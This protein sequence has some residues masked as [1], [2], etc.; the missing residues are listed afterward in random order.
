MAFQHN[1]PDIRKRRQK[2]PQNFNGITLLCTAFKVFTE[3][4][5]QKTELKVGI[6]GDQQRK[7][8]K[9]TN[10]YLYAWQS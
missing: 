4:M 10:R 8:S 9:T 1:S 7:E 3:I 6:C 5:A 2:E